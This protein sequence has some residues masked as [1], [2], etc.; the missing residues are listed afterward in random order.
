[1]H[2]TEFIHPTK[3]RHQPEGAGGQGGLTLGTSSWVDVGCRAQHRACAGGPLVLGP[4]LRI[5]S[6]PLAHKSWSEASAGLS[7]GATIIPL[8]CWADE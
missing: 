1:M 7:A 3:L 5:S 4:W 6:V 2:P 8:S